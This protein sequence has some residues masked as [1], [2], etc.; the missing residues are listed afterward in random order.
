MRN[1]ILT[2]IA[3]ITFGLSF[4]GSYTLIYE[5]NS[6]SYSGIITFNNQDD[7][8][9][10]KEEVANKAIDINQLDELNNSYP[11]LI[12]FSIDVDNGVLFSYGDLREDCFLDLLPIIVGSGAITLLFSIVLTNL[13]YFKDIV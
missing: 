1:V 13:K 10:F 4:W 8:A 11:L 9:Q 12:N 2:L 7:F 5:N 3:V 6:D